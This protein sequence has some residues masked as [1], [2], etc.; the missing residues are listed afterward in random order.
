[1]KYWWR[2][3]WSS[4]GNHWWSEAIKFLYLNFSVQFR[5]IGTV[6]CNTCMNSLQP[7]VTIIKC[8]NTFWH[9][10]WF[11]RRTTAWPRS[12]YR[13]SRSVLTKPIL[14]PIHLPISPGTP[15]ST[16]SRYSLVMYGTGFIEREWHYLLT[17]LSYTLTD[18]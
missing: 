14:L 8:R 13:M 5:V 15:I 11:C 10:N 12:A 18:Y 9:W 1:M 3:N 7:Q 2:I 6:V 4:F 17:P 16:V